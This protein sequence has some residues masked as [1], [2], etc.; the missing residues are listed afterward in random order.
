[1]ELNDI[2]IKEVQ[3]NKKE[4]E[5]QVSELFKYFK[6]TTGCKITNIELVRSPSLHSHSTWKIRSIIGIDIKAQLSNIKED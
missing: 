2:N 1:M 4:L 3:E 5:E 6:L